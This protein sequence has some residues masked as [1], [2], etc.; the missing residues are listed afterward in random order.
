MPEVTSASGF[1]RFFRFF[2][3]TYHLISS[4][5]SFLSSNPFDM[6]R[7]IPV[8]LI[9]T[10][11]QRQIAPRYALRAASTSTSSTPVTVPEGQ[12]PGQ[13]SPQDADA[14]DPQLAGLDYPVF[15]GASR[16]HRNPRGWWDQQERS[17]T[18]V[19]TYRERART[20]DRRFHYQD[21]LQ[22]DPPRKRRHPLNVGSRRSQNIWVVRTSKP[23]RGRHGVGGVRILREGH[24]FRR[25]RPPT[26][27]PLRWPGEGPYGTAGGQIQCGR[28]RLHEGGM[29]AH[30]SHLPAHSHPFQAREQQEGG[31]D[32]E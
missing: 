7:T 30:L 31:E 32:E 23:S 19:L 12:L 6:N 3:T 18:E 2:P 17:V 5:L 26:D 25:T 1:L 10:T 9:R 22:R 4:Q 11:A 29:S 21:E 14:V 16:Q 15:R 27:L 8:R 28:S 24:E 20:A 13:L